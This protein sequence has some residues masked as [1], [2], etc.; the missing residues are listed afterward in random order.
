MIPVFKNVDERFLANKYSPV[1]FP[2]VVSKTFELLI[3]NRTVDHLEKY[4]H[5]SCF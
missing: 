2:S 5:F 3:N 4:D 1:I